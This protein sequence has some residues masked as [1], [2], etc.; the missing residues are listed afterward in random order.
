[1]I[2]WGVVIFLYFFIGRAIPMESR[3]LIWC[4]LDDHVPFVPAFALP[5]VAW[6]FLLA[7]TAWHCYRKE[8]R[9]FRNFVG[10]ILFGYAIAITTFVLYPSA[11]DFRPEVL[12]QDVFSW[13][14]AFVYR[15]D[16]PTNVLPSLHVILAMGIAF[17]LGKTK[18]FGKPLS[19]ILW[20]LVALSIC[21]ST[22]LIKQHSVLDI[23]GAIPV[24]CTGW[25]LFFRK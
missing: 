9:I 12:G 6:F 8:R 4:I 15:M 19:R 23:L 3:R 14:V 20:W 25:L 2:L 21:A 18:T 7:F 1:M 16:S 24:C 17:A 10:Y 22:V 13:L 11:I 5:Y